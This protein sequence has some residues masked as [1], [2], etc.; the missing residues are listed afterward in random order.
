[1]ISLVSSLCD[2][3]GRVMFNLKFRKIFLA[4]FQLQA[5][6]RSRLCDQIAQFL[7]VLGKKIHSKVSQILGDVLGQ[8]EKHHCLSTIARQFL[9]NLGYFLFQHLATLERDKMIQVSAKQNEVERV[10]CQDSLTILCTVLFTEHSLTLLE[11]QVGKGQN[12][13]IALQD[14]SPTS[15]ELFPDYFFS[16]LL[17]YFSIQ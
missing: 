11:R 15:N 8:L 13:F 16:T 1:M 3:F 7:E 5:D 10:L 2:S 12:I 6:L 9:E 14:Q 4:I 17:Y